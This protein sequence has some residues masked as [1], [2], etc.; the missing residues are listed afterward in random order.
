MGNM[1]TQRMGIG[2]TI[3]VECQVEGCGVG[4]GDVHGAQGDGE[5]SITAIE[6]ESDVIMKLTVVK[7]GQPGYNVPNMAMYGGN[8]IKRMSP[9][10]FVSFYG[11]PERQGGRT[12][13]SQ[14]RWA[15]EHAAAPS[16]A[17]R[18]SPSRCRSPRRTPSPRRS[19]S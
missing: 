12:C 18:S 2:T 10:E 15:N 5:L 4:T 9:G 11:M 1:D 14:Y 7:P 8:S 19:S 6:M 13:A 16:S 17:R 3:Y